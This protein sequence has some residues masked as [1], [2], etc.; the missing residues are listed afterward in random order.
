VQEETKALG[1]M[2]LRAPLELDFRC[3]VPEASDTIFQL[4]TQPTIRV[5]LYDLRCV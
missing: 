4:T 2:T 1:G 5:V 3:G